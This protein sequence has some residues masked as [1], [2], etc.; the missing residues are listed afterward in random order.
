MTPLDYHRIN[1]WPLT[2]D[3]DHNWYLTKPEGGLTLRERLKHAYWILRGKAIA[4]TWI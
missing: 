4:A 2:E 3:E 1:H